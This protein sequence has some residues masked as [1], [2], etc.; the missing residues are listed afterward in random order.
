MARVFAVVHGVALGFLLS[1]LPVMI[2]RAITK[3]VTNNLPLLSV[4]PVV[5]LLFVR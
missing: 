4:L 3:T 5:Q 2:Y 1:R